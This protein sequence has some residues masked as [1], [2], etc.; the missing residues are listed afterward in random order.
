M[1]QQPTAQKSP[2]SPASL[3]WAPTRKVRQSVPNS[4]SDGVS[5]SSCSVV[6]HLYVKMPSLFEAA[7]LRG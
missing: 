1:A 7:Q 2:I 5:L 4:C 6:S 3:G